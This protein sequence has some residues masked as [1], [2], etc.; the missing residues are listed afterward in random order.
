MPIL[1]SASLQ[2]MDMSHVADQIRVLNRHMDRYHVDVADGHYVDSIM[3]GD[4]L[5]RDIESITT[6]PVDVHLAVERPEALFARF[7]DTSVDTICVHVENTSQKFFRLARQ[8]ELAGKRLGAVLNPMTGPEPLRYAGDVVSKVTVMT[9][10]PGFAGQRFIGTM[11]K[12]V[13]ELV[14]LR[15]REG[16]QFEIEVDGNINR[17]TIPSLISAGASTLVLGTSGLFRP[18]VALEIAAQ[19]IREFCSMPD[20]VGD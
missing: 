5:V 10:D 9:V 2:C 1:L 17:N 6:L 4:Q 18:G 7:C 16:Y 13:S 3:L 8:A 12:K 14:D 15:E 19:E 11:G 20:T